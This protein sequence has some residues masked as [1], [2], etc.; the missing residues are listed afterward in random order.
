MLIKLSYSPTCSLKKK[1]AWF[2]QPKS[3]IKSANLEQNHCF[4]LHILLS[5]HHNFHLK[6]TGATIGLL[7]ALPVLQGRILL[8]FP[9]PGGCQTPA[10]KQSRV[11]M[12]SM[13]SS[14]GLGT[15][16]A[17]DLHLF[18]SFPLLRL[19]ALRFYTI[20]SNPALKHFPWGW[21]NRG[22]P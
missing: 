19:R 13:S 6:S 1:A 2:E 21:V 17:S 3:L 7:P 9:P 5:P 10:G 12:R 18:P 22:N 15:A 4:K 8:P 20:T 14:P 11:R 16:L